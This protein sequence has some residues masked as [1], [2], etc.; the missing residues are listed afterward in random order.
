[1]N[2]VK[3]AA[4]LLIDGSLALTTTAQMADELEGLEPEEFW[5]DPD[6]RRHYRLLTARMAAKSLRDRKKNGHPEPESIRRE[7]DVPVWTDRKLLD[8]EGYRDRLQHCREQGS[9]YDE[10]GKHLLHQ[11]VDAGHEQLRAEFPEFW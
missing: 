1:M 11:A 7:D 10:R 8:I 9:Y 2:P 5:A 6:V 4:S 3:W